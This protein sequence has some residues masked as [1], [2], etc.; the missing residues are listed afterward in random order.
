MEMCIEN[1]GEVGEGDLLI[2]GYRLLV[3]RGVSSRELMLM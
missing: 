1:W 3:T 2:K